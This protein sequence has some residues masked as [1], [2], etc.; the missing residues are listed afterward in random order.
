MLTK[1]LSR[2]VLQRPSLSIRSLSSNSAQAAPV[3][4]YTVWGE[5]ERNIHEVNWSLVEDGVI[6][7]GNAYRNERVSLLTSHL[8]EKVSGNKVT[9]KDVVYSG[10]Y[11]VLEA[12][13][14]IDHSAFSNLL[15]ETQ[16]SLSNGTNLYVED[17]SIGAFAGARVGVRVITAMPAMAL[18]ARSLLVSNKNN[19]FVGN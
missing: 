14:N 19:C 15:S 10:K 18:V 16:S 9:V 2:N 13:D 8:T 6:P 11:T 1:F 4:K 17:A 5:S 3:S 7:V 12:G